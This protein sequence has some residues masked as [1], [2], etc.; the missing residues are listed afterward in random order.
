MYIVESGEK[1]KRI[2]IADDEALIRRLVC[3]FLKNAGYETIEAVDGKDAIDKFY[4]VGSI[5]LV[6][7]D[8]MMPE[9]DG[10]EVCRKIRE[11]SS[12]PILVLTARS[13]EFDE[14]MSFESGADD[15]VTKPFS[16]G[17]LVKRVE[18]LLKRSQNK[19]ESKSDEI[20]SVDGLVIDIPAHKVTHDGKTIEL[21]IKEHN[22][23]VKLASNPERIYSRE[24]LLDSIWGVDFIGDSRTV[25]SHVARLRTKLGTW[26][27]KH[28]K[29]VYGVGYKIEVTES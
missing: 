10:W 29:T 7:C 13:Q 2:L 25:D 8:I 15:Y 23:L 26:G 9:I 18:A 28:L 22:I 27:E 16:P 14:I 21:T 11:T 24:Q 3:D 5:S 20:I 4:S 6:I 17:V 1:M 12:V 19:N